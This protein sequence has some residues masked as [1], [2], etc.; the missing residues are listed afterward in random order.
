MGRYAC[1]L[2]LLQDRPL[3][4]RC[5]VLWASLLAPPQN[6]PSS[7]FGLFQRLL[8]RVG[9]SPRKATSPLC[10]RPAMWR[11]YGLKN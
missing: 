3:R 2:T 9:R 8:C 1:T 5:V 11:A 6:S 4:R 7:S 10:N